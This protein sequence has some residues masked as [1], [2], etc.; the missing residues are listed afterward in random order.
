MV[1]NTSW[2]NRMTVALFY[3]FSCSS[4]LLPLFCI[5][6]VKLLSIHEDENTYSLKCAS[7]DSLKTFILDSIGFSW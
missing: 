6:R 7:K 4:S 5:V 1:E 2:L 3:A